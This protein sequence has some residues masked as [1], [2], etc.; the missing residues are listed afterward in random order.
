M[1]EVV[2]YSDKIVRTSYL[3]GGVIISI[4]IEKRF[5]CTNFLR[6]VRLRDPRTDLLRHDYKFVQ[7]SF[8]ALYL[9]AQIYILIVNEQ[10]SR[11]T[12][13]ILP[14]S[15]SRRFHI[16]AVIECHFSTEK[17][18]DWIIPVLIYST[19][20]VMFFISCNLHLQ[21]SWLRNSITPI[22]II[23]L[24]QHQP[25]FFVDDSLFKMNIFSMNFV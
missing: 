4:S 11:F 16:H 21:F 24:K 20:S 5:Y 14:L 9:R 7:C 10:I 19:F 15:R 17:P 18:S 6:F 8:F 25:F 1:A 2:L 13:A 12:T 3:L 23:F 22:C